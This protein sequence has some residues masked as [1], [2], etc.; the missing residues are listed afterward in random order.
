MSA[1]L[2]YI[3]ISKANLEHNIGEFRKRLPQGTTLVAVVKA[4]AYG[5]GLKEIVS[6]AEPIV[7]AFQ[8]DDIEEL[9]ALRAFTAKPAYV[10]G[11]VRLDDLAE[12]ISL[13]AT[14]GVYTIETISRL[15]AIAQKSGKIIPVH[16]KIDALLGRQGI[17][18]EAVHTFIEEA[19]KYSHVQ[20]E[21]VYSHF[22][23]IEDT[24]DLDH[25]RVQ[26]KALM[27]AKLHVATHGF[28]DVRHH[29]S[30]TSGFLVEQ[31]GNWGGT[32]VRLGIGMYGLWPSAQLHKRF[33]GS[34]ELRP[35]LSWMTKLAQVKEVPAGYPIGYGLSY[36]AS[37]PMKIAIVPQGYSDGYDRGFSNNSFVL[38]GGTVCPIVGRVAMNMFAVDVSHL[39][40]VR[41]EDEAVLIGN[42]FGSAEDRQG[43][44]ISA[45]MLAERIGTINYEI[46]ARIS[47][48]LPRIMQ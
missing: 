46:V 5:H 17:V 3:E 26:Y 1:P 29:I 2:S 47:P 7:D 16:L 24:D 18:L 10:F 15:S 30:A 41:Q 36:V 27:E 9:R 34:I 13:G 35:V 6:I 42:S 12:A 4:N 19:K 32:F 40:Y 38:I 43:K 44:V 48:L 31:E 37:Q 11:Y 21:A 8:V 45:D 20:I 39:Q 25:A 14:L 23:N 33:S 22:S 28:P